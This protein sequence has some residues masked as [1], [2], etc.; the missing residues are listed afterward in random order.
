MVVEGVIVIIIT[1]EIEG[2]TIE[3]MG[4][5]EMEMEDMGT[6]MGVDLVLVGV[7]MDR[8][9]TIMVTKTFLELSEQMK[10]FR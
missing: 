3:T 2:Q 10:I 1:T 5:I 9:E 7:N 4:I 8:E 6:S